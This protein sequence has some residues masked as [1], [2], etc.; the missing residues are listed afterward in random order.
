MRIRI[1]PQGAVIFPG[2][3][4]GSGKYK[5]K[6][7]KYVKIRRFRLTEKKYGRSR[8][9]LEERLTKWLAQALEGFS[10]L[11]FKI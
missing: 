6:M 3:P 9:A 7:D 10:Y 5:E 8:G 4:G 2:E 1:V 11:N